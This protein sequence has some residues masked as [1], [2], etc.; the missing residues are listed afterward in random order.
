IMKLYEESPQPLIAPHVSRTTDIAFLIA[1]RLER[2][3]KPVFDPFKRRA[4]VTSITAHDLGRK[5]MDIRLNNLI[6]ELADKHNIAVALC[7]DIYDFPVV[8][9]DELKQEAGKLG[10]TSSEV[11]SGLLVELTHAKLSWEI[12]QNNWPQSLPRFDER[13]M[14]LVKEAIVHHHVPWQASFWS[15]RIAQII[16]AAD[17]IEK[18]NNLS[19]RMCQ[20][21]R[22]VTLTLE[23]TVRQLEMAWKDMRLDQEV[24]VAAITVIAEQDPQF[25]RV[26]LSAREADA[27]PSIDCE[28]I[29]ILRTRLKGYKKRTD[30]QVAAEQRRLFEGKKT[31]LGGIVAER[32]DYDPTKLRDAFGGREKEKYLKWVI[33]LLRDHGIGFR[34][35][36]IDGLEDLL[37]EADTLNPPARKSKEGVNFK[38]ALEIFESEEKESEILNQI[39]ETNFKN[40][41][42]VFDRRR[43]QVVPLKIIRL[44]DIADEGQAYRI[45]HSLHRWDKTLPYSLPAAVKEAVS[46]LLNGEAKPHLG[47]IYLAVSEYDEVEGI[48]AMPSWEINIAPQND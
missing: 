31:I 41:I 2:T 44:L 45:R 9:L 19:T 18:V 4:L 27:L 15:K 5:G 6:I 23:D 1:D 29:E 21:T 7:E 11:W 37:R 38:Q 42:F 28:F 10:Y 30:R 3:S 16:C 48:V 33:R 34:G 36:F 13:E 32:Y 14:N 40:E 39:G 24:F 20:A 35:I 22:T 25:V 46:Y 47:G 43:G 17:I 8:Y 26:I 12:L